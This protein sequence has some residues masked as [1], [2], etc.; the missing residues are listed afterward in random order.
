MVSTFN[1]KFFCVE[2][3]YTLAKLCRTWQY[4]GEDLNLFVKRF[5]EKALECSD[6]VDEEILVN[7]CL[8]DM[9]NG[10]RVFLE[11]IFYLSYSK[12]MKASSDG[13]ARERTP[14]PS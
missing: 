5:H 13:Q 11:N 1:V 8:Y 12:L 7:V 10:C 3:K 9:D 4:P 2:A 14:K 6:P